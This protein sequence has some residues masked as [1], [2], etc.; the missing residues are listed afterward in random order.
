MGRF[1]NGCSYKMRDL[2]QG[3]PPKS[4][5]DVP[6]VQ[7]IFQGHNQQLLTAMLDNA[8]CG[9]TGGSK[10]IP[11]SELTKQADKVAEVTGD[12]VSIEVEYWS[13]YEG[14]KTTRYI[15]WM[16]KDKPE[17]GRYKTAQ[18]L[19]AAMENIIN[20]QADEGVTV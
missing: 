6:G 3:V 2:R 19:Q 8:A 13:H 5:L 10:M 17:N 12:S 4:K 9:Y 1:S 11:F 16:G 20:P 15:F 14:T 7:W 18:E